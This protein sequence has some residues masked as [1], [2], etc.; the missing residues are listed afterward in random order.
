MSGQQ[1][2]SRVRQVLSR[3]GAIIFRNRARW[4]FPM[5]HP[6]TSSGPDIA[7]AFT[8]PT[9]HHA[10]RDGKY[11]RFEKKS[12]TVMAGW[13]RP[14]AWQRS[15]Q[16]PQWRMVRPVIPRPSLTEPVACTGPCA[17]G[18]NDSRSHHCQRHENDCQ[19][20]HD[21]WLLWCAEI[22]SEVR[23]AIAPYHERYWHLLSLAARCG[24][25]A[26]DL[27]RSNPAL[28]WALASSW[29]FR[30]KPVQAPMRSAR[31][32][33][34]GGASQRR[35]LAWLDFPATDSARR[36]LRKLDHRS[37]KVSALLNLR[38]GM[39]DPE[40]M[41]RLRHLP[42]LNHGVIRLACDR[43]LRPWVTPQ[44]LLDVALAGTRQ[45]YI[46]STGHDEHRFS[47]TAM[48][49]LECYD[50]VIFEGLN[51]SRLEGIH[52]IA[53]LKRRHEELAQEAQDKAPGKRNISPPPFAGTGD[54]VPLSSEQ[55]MIEEG[56]L[57]AHCV[58]SLRGWAVHGGFAFYRVLAPERATL[59]IGRQDEG[60]EIV[61]LRL[62]RNQEPAAATW[63]AVRAW[64]RDSQDN[65]N[66]SV[67]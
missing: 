29:V 61:E 15:V 2:R 4:M 34:H 46:Q 65:H 17:I 41:K 55:L 7:P 31:R 21:P 44:L 12:V 38:D 43:S 26:L 57:M 16:H 10:F 39:R 9:G 24:E 48:K 47:C 37:I 51:L 67:M 56:E 6:V 60:W 33:L 45:D 59:S 66:F 27:M 32:L 8:K 22:P 20:A 63:Q 23:T 58:G 49:F 14:L 30:A 28:A 53:D 5:H 18:F 40:T 11:Y 50:L 25:P 35:I 64:L 13:P 52:S 3:P 19:R 62:A 36:L 1:Y 42:T 54:I